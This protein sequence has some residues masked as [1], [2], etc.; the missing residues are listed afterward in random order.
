[1][2][3]VEHPRSPTIMN[4]ETIRGH[5]PSPPQGV[6]A[7]ACTRPGHIRDPILDDRELAPGMRQRRSHG[8]A[9]ATIAAVPMRRIVSDGARSTLPQFPPS[10]PSSVIHHDEFPLQARRQRA[11]RTR[12]S[13]A[14]MNSS[15]LYRGIRIE[16]GQ[17]TIIAVVAEGFSFT[18]QV[19]IHLL[20]MGLWRDSMFRRFWMFAL[21]RSFSAPLGQQG[22]ELFP[23]WTPGILDYPPDQHRTRNFRPAHLSRWD[24]GSDRL[25]RSLRTIIR[26]AFPASAG[27]ASRAP[28]RMDRAATSGACWPMSEP[29]RW[30][31][32]FSPTCTTTTSE[33]SR[34][35]KVSKW[36]GLQTDGN[37]RGREYVPIRTIIDRAS[38]ITTTPNRSPRRC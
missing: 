8:G 11:A 9:F 10:H 25:R 3:E 33:P 36:R 7:N 26:V 20:P 4:R 16:R 28:E 31:T 30:I 32:R 13:R 22:G 27:F 2:P 29:P 18:R 5:R 34:V 23:A 1:M 12:S 19:A 35:S 15:S 38:R 24:N 6:S 17:L 21:L 37:H 14:A